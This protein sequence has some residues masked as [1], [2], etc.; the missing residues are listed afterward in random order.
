W[1]LLVLEGG[2]APVLGVVASQK[3]DWGRINVFA[4]LVVNPKTRSRAIELLEA[5]PQREQ[6]D[7]MHEVFHAHDHLRPWASNYVLDGGDR[8]FVRV[9]GVF[10]SMAWGLWEGSRATEEVLSRAVEQARR[11]GLGRG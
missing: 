8:A 9:Y 6:V 4:A 11:A 5:L 1:L 10:R 3:E 7:V 2:D